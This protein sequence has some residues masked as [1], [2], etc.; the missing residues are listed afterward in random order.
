MKLVVPGMLIG[1]PVA[2]GCLNR[3]AISNDQTFLTEK[4]LA[5]L[6]ESKKEV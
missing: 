5:M 3:S 6:L 2:T 1:T 4:M